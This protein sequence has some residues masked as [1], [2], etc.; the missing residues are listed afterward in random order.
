MAM[1][2]RLDPDQDRLLQELADAQG[3]SKQEA[4]SRAIVE[5]AERRLHSAQ[6]SQLS[7]RARERY[8]DVLRRLGE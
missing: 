7:S 4:A 6:V 3:I 2:L 8:A 5:T 1:T